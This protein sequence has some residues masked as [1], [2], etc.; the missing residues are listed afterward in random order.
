LKYKYSIYQNTLF[1]LNIETNNHTTDHKH[2]FIEMT[3]LDGT[4]S[5]KDT[6]KV[7]V[8]EKI[9]EVSSKEWETRDGRRVQD[10]YEEENSIVEG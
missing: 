4:V 3:E 6:F 1:F 8:K 7:E 5:F 9:Y 2:L 10:L